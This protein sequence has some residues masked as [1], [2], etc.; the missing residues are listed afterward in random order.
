MTSVPPA[1]NGTEGDVLII[2]I[3][4]LMATATFWTYP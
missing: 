2:W 4:E 1:A 3:R